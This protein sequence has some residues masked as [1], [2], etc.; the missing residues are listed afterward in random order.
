MWLSFVLGLAS[1]SLRPKRSVQFQMDQVAVSVIFGELQVLSESAGLCGIVFPCIPRPESLTLEPTRR[2][3]ISARISHYW[4]E[5]DTYHVSVAAVADDTGVTSLSRLVGR[6]CILQFMR[7]PLL[8]LASYLGE[9][10]KVY[11]A[12]ALTLQTSPRVRTEP[13]GLL[14]HIELGVV[15]F[16]CLSGRVVSTEEPEGLHVLLENRYG[17]ES[18]WLL[19]LHEVSLVNT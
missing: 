14:T 8:P 13:D 12:E 5:T 4:S 6:P 10:V 17:G 15:R 18:T 11:T 7:K 2:E 19:T 16:R 1:A 3:T 9:K